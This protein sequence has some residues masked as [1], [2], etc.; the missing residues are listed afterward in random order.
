MTVKL[1]SGFHLIYFSDSSYEKI[2]VEI[3]YKGEQIAQINQDK[4]INQLQIEILVNH[5]EQNFTP[6]F[7]LDDFLFALKEAKKIILFPDLYESIFVKN[8]SD[9]I[10]IQNEV[11]RQQ[12]KQIL[13]DKNVTF[14]KLG[15]GELEAS[16]PDGRGARFNRDGS[17]SGFI[18]K[19]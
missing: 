8:Y 10:S 1:N 11:A 19:N 5:R 12:L 15:K 3:Q 16:L 2:T 6:K 7:M 9:D 13:E 4:G 17:F 18:E 14:I